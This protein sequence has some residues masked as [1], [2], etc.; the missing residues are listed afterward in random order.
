MYLFAKE[1]GVNAPRRFESSRLRLRLAVAR[2]RRDAVRQKT[3][4][5]GSLPR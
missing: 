3:S 4:E 2:L 5:G 1:A